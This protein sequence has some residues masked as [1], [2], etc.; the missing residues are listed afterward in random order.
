MNAVQVITGSG[1]WPMTV[2]LTP[3]LVPFHAGTYF[4]PEDRGG[5]PGFSKI[6][7]VISE[8]YCSHRGEVQ[9]VEAQMKNALRQITEMVPSDGKL[10]DQILTNAF[11]ASVL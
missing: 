4:P 11:Q 5:M 6:L 10:E 2:F 7:V 3:D 1:G 8:Y 9:R